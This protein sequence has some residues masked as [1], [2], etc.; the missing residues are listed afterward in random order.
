MRV[1]I[2]YGFVV[3]RQGLVA[4]LSAARRASVLALAP[5]EILSVTQISVEVIFAT[6]RYDVCLFGLSGFSLAL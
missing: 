4:A 1:F 3:V 2:G 6:A 5:G